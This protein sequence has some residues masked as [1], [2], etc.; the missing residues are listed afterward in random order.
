MEK[1]AAV[2]LVLSKVQT[3][4]LI[5]GGSLGQ[6]VLPIPMVVVVV[7]LIVSLDKVVLVVLVLFASSGAIIAPIPLQIQKMLFN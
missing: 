7:A 6:V 1:G 3:Q 4:L 2:V 5:L